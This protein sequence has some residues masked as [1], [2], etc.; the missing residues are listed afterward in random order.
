[1]I[2]KGGV[3]WQKKGGGVGLIVKNALN[4]KLEEICVGNELKSE[5]IL[6]MRYE[7][8]QANKCIILVVC[9]MTTMGPL[10]QEENVKK[11]TKLERVAQKFSR[12]PVI[13]MG[14]MNSHVGILG[15]K[16]NENG[17]KLVD[18]CEGYEFE[19]GE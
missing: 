4:S 7:K 6:A 18:F 17:H 12:F 10:A 14:D 19:M 16:V 3:K 5:D 8:V 9:Y 15:E 1:M 13:V 11:Y 2:G